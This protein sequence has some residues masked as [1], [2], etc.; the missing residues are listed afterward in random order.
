M[1]ADRLVERAAELAEGTAG[2]VLSVALVTAGGE[3]RSVT[4][5]APD[6]ERLPS[7]SSFKPAVAAAVRA[8][9]VAPPVAQRHQPSARADVGP[10]QAQ[11]R[12]GR[13]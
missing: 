7:C 8:G 9:E 11:C 10:H 1:E 2:L 3:E 6:G 12:I 5:G 4:I 13:P